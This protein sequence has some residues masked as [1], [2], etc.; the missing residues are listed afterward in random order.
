MK[1][2]N[3]DTIGEKY[4]KNQ[5]G[6]MAF[7]NNSKATTWQTHYSNL[8]KVEFPWNYDDLPNKP[9]AHGPP[10]FITSNHK[11]ISQMK[12]RKAAGPSG[13]TLEMILASQQHIPHLTKL[14]N[15]TPA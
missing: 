11:T 9:A 12:K 14:A 13:V 4:V 6:N 10:I 3:K 7:D 1:D 5:E 15:N 8:P 2:D